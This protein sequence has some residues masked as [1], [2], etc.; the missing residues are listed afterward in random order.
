MIGEPERDCGLAVR[1]EG[2]CDSLIISPGEGTLGSLSCKFM[3]TV[4]RRLPA[5]EDCRFLVAELPEE[6]RGDQYPSAHTG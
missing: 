6:P 5:C 1:Y 4:E 2:S 3:S